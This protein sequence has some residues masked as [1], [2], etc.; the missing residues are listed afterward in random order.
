MPRDRSEGRLQTRDRFRSCRKRPSPENCSEIDQAWAC[1]GRNRQGDLGI[2]AQDQITK[3][4]VEEVTGAGS[5]L[6]PQLPSCSSWRV[7]FLLQYIVEAY[8]DP[9]S[10]LA[11]SEDD[12]KCL[13]S[14]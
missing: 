2:G 3:G 7:A 10:R 5:G 13:K 14:P 8:L 9:P 12:Q 11:P 1:F 4:G 6:L